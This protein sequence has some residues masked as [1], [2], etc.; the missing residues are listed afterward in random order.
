MNFL[1]THLE[2]SRHLPTKQVEHGNYIKILTN[3]TRGDA[4]GSN[5]VLG[6]NTLR[7]KSI[8]ATCTLFVQLN[9]SISRAGVFVTNTTLTRSISFSSFV[10][11]GGLLAMKALQHNLNI[12][13][14]V[15]IK[16]YMA[17]HFPQSNKENLDVKH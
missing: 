9:S 14:V 5:D 3:C 7:Y 12:R 13:T 2:R 17:L 6:G 10:S 11:N 1:C 4:L 15:L 8:N 16:H